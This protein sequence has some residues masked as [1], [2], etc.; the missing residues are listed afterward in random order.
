M[1]GVGLGDPGLETSP[2]AGLLCTQHLHRRLVGP[3]AAS[4]FTDSPEVTQQ[5]GDIVCLPL[6]R[7]QPELVEP[8]PFRLELGFAGLRG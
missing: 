6:A 3:H 8:W 2:A 5:P 7:G 1:G 4:V